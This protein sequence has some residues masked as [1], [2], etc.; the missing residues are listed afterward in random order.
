MCPRRDLAWDAGCGNGQFSVALAA[1]FSRVIATD[2]SQQQLDAASPHPRVE[3]RQGKA[4]ERVLDAGSADLAVAAQAAH[5]FD[6]P[7][8]VDEVARVTRPG[9]LVALVSYATMTLDGEAHDLVMRYYRDDVGPYW[10]KGREQIENAYRDLQWPWPELAAPSIPMT[11]TWS[12]DEL[13]GY[14]STWSATVKML[15]VEGP[16]KYER[17]VDALARVWPDDE[18]RTVTWPLLVRLARR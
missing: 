16:T 2:P 15:E 13:L 8:Y 11:A 17:L 4:E 14:I 10:P 12:R 1:H 7:R 18:R 6:W 5:W 3:Y 9:S